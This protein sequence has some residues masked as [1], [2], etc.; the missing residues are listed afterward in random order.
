MVDGRKVSG[1][2]LETNVNSGGE[3]DGLVV[4]MG[5][6]VFNAPDLAVCL[7]DVADDPVY[8]TKIRDKILEE[9][10]AAYTLWQEEGFTSIREQWLSHAHGLGQAMTARLPNIS[11]KGIFDGLT[12]EGSLIL[13]Q[14]SGEKMIITS[15]DVHFG[16]D[17]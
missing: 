10:G 5:V 1:I 4:G 17:T 13:T 8:V 2:L 9:L 12:E 3:L 6:N 7:N 15:G 16:D 14:D 11:H